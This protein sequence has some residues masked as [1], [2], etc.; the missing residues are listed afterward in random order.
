MAWSKLIS[1]S[2]LD[3]LHCTTPHLDHL[4][5]LRKSCSSVLFI[6]S[7]LPYHDDLSKCHRMIYPLDE[8]SWSHAHFSKR[9]HNLIFRRKRK[10]KRLTESSR[11]VRLVS[12]ASLKVAHH[13]A[14]IEQLRILLTGWCSLSVRKISWSHCEIWTHV[15]FLFNCCWALPQNY[16]KSRA[17]IYFEGRRVRTLGPAMP[18]SFLKCLSEEGHSFSKF[19]N[20]QTPSSFHFPQICHLRRQWW[21]CLF[22]LIAYVWITGSNLIGSVGFFVLF[23][24]P[25]FTYWNT[26]WSRLWYSSACGYGHV[27]TLA[28]V[29]VRNCK[30]DITAIGIAAYR[31]Y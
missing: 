9:V 6:I 14:E 2:V 1:F 30:G 26:S 29:S 3:E 25:Y 22:F 31:N 23:S 5:T 17:L 11:S 4:C 20:S 13:E 24:Y 27:K 8:P 12:L 7:D 15:G 18:A 28:D 19:N 21:N 10:K 16:Y